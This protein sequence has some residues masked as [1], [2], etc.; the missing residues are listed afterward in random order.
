MVGEMNKRGWIRI[1]EAFVAVLLIISVLLIV[2]GGRFV[3][4]ED[5]SSEI[6]DAQLNV[7]RDIQ[8]NE[9]LR[10]E[11]LQGVI[12]TEVETKIDYRLN[13]LNCNVEICNLN[14]ECLSDGLPEDKNIYVQSVAIIDPAGSLSKQLKLFCWEK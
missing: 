3:Q 1:V 6:H 2:L 7:L 8:V 4:R 12:P 9:D 14:E 10:G 5:S 13:Y 11:I